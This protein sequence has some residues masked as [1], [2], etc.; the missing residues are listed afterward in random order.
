MS[1]GQLFSG[2][3][4]AL[5]DTIG[6]N[7][8]FYLS[9]DTKILFGPKTGGSWTGVLEVEFTGGKLLLG[10]GSPSG[11]VGDLGD[12]YLDTLNGE[13]YGP[14]LLVNDWGTMPTQIIRQSI[15][16]GNGVPGAIPGA[17]ADDLYLD[18]DTKIL[19]D[20]IDGNTWTQ[21]TTFSGSFLR[22]TGAPTAMIGVDGDSYF[23]ESGG[24]LYGP[25]AS[26]VW[27]PSPIILGEGGKLLSGSGTTILTGSFGVN[28]DYYVDR[29]SL[30]IYG[31]KTGN[32]WPVLGS[33]NP[34]TGVQ[35]KT[36]AQIIIDFFEK[37][38]WG[39]ILVVFL[40]IVI[41]IFLIFR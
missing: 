32:T 1:G 31:P 22:G 7:G 26:G 40:L 39:S 14:K 37:I 20:T 33:I 25:K 2:L 12:S 24:A 29:N 8:D 23:D 11:T 21:I 28:G 19:Y 18:L 35:K 41:I 34:V 4:S 17:R 10:T 15:L 6:V 13:I 36:Y 30:V 3:E 27:P 38:G 9:E 16:T 5:N